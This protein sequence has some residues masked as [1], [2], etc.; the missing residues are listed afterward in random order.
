MMCGAGYSFKMNLKFITSTIIRYETRQ[1]TWNFEFMLIQILNCNFRG[2]VNFEMKVCWG[3]VRNR[4]WIFG[5]D[6]LHLLHQD[7][8][9]VSCQQTTGLHP[10]KSVSVRRQRAWSHPVGS[11]WNGPLRTAAPQHCSPQA[12]LQTFQSLPPKWSFGDGVGKW[13]GWTWSSEPLAPLRCC[14]CRRSRGLEFS[15]T[16]NSIKALLSIR[17]YV[18]GIQWAYGWVW[19]IS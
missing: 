5:V 13:M 11:H 17:N 14:Y 16:G 4:P 9:S 3:D 6:S 1:E 12:S 19:F 8:S 10:A 7:C 18:N 2:R 15:E